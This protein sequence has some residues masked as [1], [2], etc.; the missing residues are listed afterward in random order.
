[1]TMTTEDLAEIKKKYNT[2][3][4]EAV[5]RYPG[6]MNLPKLEFAL[7]PGDS[8]LVVALWTKEEEDQIPL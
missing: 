1:M 3:K 4:P 8:E 6:A 7:P 5:G 2:P